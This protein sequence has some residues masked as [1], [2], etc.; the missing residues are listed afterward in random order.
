MWMA[1]RSIPRMDI[2][3]L[4]PRML[5]MIAAIALP[6]QH[7]LAQQ[8]NAGQVDEA[9]VV[10]LLGTGTPIPT[11]DQFGPAV[12]VQAGGMSLLFDCGRGCTTR[13][14]QIDRDLVS[15]IDHLFIT[16]LHSDHL[17]GIPDLY[18]N[19]WTQGRDAPLMNWGPPGT[20]SMFSHL[21]EAFGEDIRL[22]IEKGVPPTT[23]G[24][25]MSTT[26]IAGDQVVLDEDGL[27]VI[28]FLVDHGPIEP[29]FGYRINYGEYSVVISGDTRPSENLVRQSQGADVVL[30]EVLSPQQVAYIRSTFNEEQSETVI[31]IHTTAE[32]AGEVFAQ[33]RPRLAVYYHTRNTVADVA[34]LYQDTARTYDGSVVVAEDLLQIEIGAE[35]ALRMVY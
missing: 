10:T 30:H 32:Q 15:E 21:R 17:V 24:I 3:R 35:I 33:I 31:G 27:Q 16:H 26:E 7:A 4:A 28:A 12:L 9:I 20:L 23:D 1:G 5:F 13:L 34:A 6:T 18:L 2:F 19:G 11:P 14:A 8:D 25:A 29:A 22:R